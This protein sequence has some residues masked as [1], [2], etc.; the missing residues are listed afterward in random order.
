MDP[1]DMLR[2]T[3]EASYS[4]GNLTTLRL[5]LVRVFES[6]MGVSTDLFFLIHNYGR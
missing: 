6:P 1:M 4:L 5:D 3:A 2:V